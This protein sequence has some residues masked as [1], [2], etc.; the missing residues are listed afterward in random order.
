MNYTKRSKRAWMERACTC[1]SGKIQGGVW[2]DER[3]DPNC[4]IHGEPTPEMDVAITGPPN[5]TESLLRVA[6]V[7]PTPDVTEHPPVSGVDTTVER[8]DV[9]TIAEMLALYH[10]G[11]E[12]SFTTPAH[13]L[14]RARA[15]FDNLSTIHTLQAELDRLA[16]ESIEQTTRIGGLE[17]KLKHFQVENARLRDTVSY[18]WQTAAQANR[19]SMEVDLEDICEKCDQVLTGEQKE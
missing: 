16:T 15:I 7:D 3:I 18:I 14:G 12:E 10:R 11:S 4:P 6:N 5:L 9:E 17:V 8:E 13:Y 19:V 1:P 2:T